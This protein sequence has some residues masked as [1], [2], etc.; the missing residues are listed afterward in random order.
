MKKHWSHKIE[1]IPVINELVEISKK[2]VLPGFDGVPLYYV[3]RF[4]IR[5]LSEGFITNRAAAMAFSFFM[6][7]FPAII[8]LFTLIPYIPIDNFQ[9]ILLEQLQAVLPKE[10]YELSKDTILDIAT[11]PRGGLLSFGFI[12]ALFFA[13]N[14][15]NAMID[16]FNQ[17]QL[18][19]E[20]RTFIQQRLISIFLVLLI[21]VL[22]IVA[23]SL[24]VFNEI[25]M[26]YLLSH[27][28]LKGGWDVFVIQISRW[29]IITALF[30]FTI[31]F[32]YYYA[33][34]GKR[35]FKFFNAGSTLATIL[36]I[37]G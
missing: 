4:F 26:D 15:I 11:R 8:F 7:L 1:N 5:A 3:L 19:I 12:S 37:L 34:S 10:A 33:P 16:A 13:T 22:T 14:G 31:S 9:D 18:S 30:Y 35:R 21:T 6:A 23:V 24:I 29:I 25:A 36:I 2:L 32:I 27:H 20:K 28:I 17:T